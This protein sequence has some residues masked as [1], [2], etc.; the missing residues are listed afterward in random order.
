MQ[1]MAGS[2]EAVAWMP[3][4]LIVQAAMPAG[5][6]ALII[7]NNYREDSSTGLRAILATAVGS[8][9]TTPLWLFTDCR[10]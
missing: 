7:V 8:V 6:F 10:S 1:G 5:V 4:V 9:V 2:Q 3:Q